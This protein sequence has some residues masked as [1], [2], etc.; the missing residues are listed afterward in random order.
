[1][2]TIGFLGAGAMGQLMMTNLLKTGYDLCVWNRTA[3]RCH[4]LVAQGARQC[5]TPREVAQRSDIVIAMLTDDEASRSAWLDA[6]TGAIN[7]LK[8]NAVAIECSTLSHACCLELAESIDKTGSCFLDA[9]VVGSRPQAV[10]CQLIHLVGGDKK[11]L[12]DIQKILKVNAAAIHHTGNIGSGM[13]MKLAVNGVFS[14]QVNVLGE[15]L[16]VLNKAGISNE[17][18]IHLFNELPVSSSA[19]KGIGLLIAAENYEPLFPVNLVEKDLRYLQQL[20]QSV[21]SNTPGID[22]TRLN[23]QSAKETGYGQENIAGVVKVFQ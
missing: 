21:Q 12:N 20:A 17:T 9:P 6:E 14:A 15:V 8:K 2:T 16:G 3:S 19:L 10:A 22:V 4:A 5:S 18:A 23:Y 1:M 11:V 13:M 7:G